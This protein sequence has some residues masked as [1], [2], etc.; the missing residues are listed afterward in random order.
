MFHQIQIR[1][2]D[3]HAQRLL[4]REDPNK[5]PDIYLMDV[6]TFGASCSPCSAQYVKNLNAEQHSTEYP[7]AA[8]AIIRK[9]YVDDYLD[10]ADNVEEAV[11]LAREVKHV[12]SQGGFYLRNWLSNSEEVLSRVGESDSATEKCLQL[13]RNIST[14]RV[15]GMFWRPEEDVFTFSTTLATEAKHPTKRQALRVVM[16]PFDPAGLLCLF[17]IHGKILIQDLWRAKTD[18]D[19]L[20]PDKSLE[21][22]LRWTDSFHQLDQIRIPRCY[23]A[24]HSTKDIVSL[25]LHVYVDASEEAYACVGYLRAV[26]PEEI[27]VALVGAKSKVAPLKAHSIPRLELMAAVIGVR[28]AKS[29]CN[30]H[31]LRIDKVFFWSDSKTVLAWINSDH[32]NYRQFVAC[33]V[34]EILSKSKAEEW[35]WIPSKKNVAD[36]ATKWGRGP[37][38]SSNSRWFRGEDDLYLPEESW[39]TSVYPAGERTNEELRSSMM[40]HEVKLPQLV[41]W[42]R[43]SNWTRLYRTVAY[44]HRYVRNLLRKTK[45]EERLVG[46]FTREEMG[47]AETT[48]FRWIQNERYPDEV[49]TLIS[50]K[51]KQ[52]NQQLRLEK[53]STIRKLSPF[54]DEADVIR[55]DSRIAAAKFVSYDTRFPVILPKGH[56]ATWLLVKW[57]HEKYLHANGETVVNEIRQRFHI[58]QLRSF[59]R[60]VSKECMLCK[61]KKSVPAI[62]RM[63]PLPA[64]RLQ[65]HVRPFSYIGIDYFGPIAVRVNRCTAKRWIA[66]FTCL[67]TRA[68]HL[69]VVHA[70]STESCKMAIRRFIG[71]RGAPVEIRSDRGTNFVG[72]SNE[73]KQEMATIE[74]QLAETFTNTH[75]DWVFNPPGAPHMGGAWER[76]VRSVKTALAAIDCPRTPSEE[77]LATVLVEAE[78]V[79]NSRPLTYIPLETDQQ[80]ALTPNHF[81]L[82]SSSGVSQTPKTLANPKQ[83]GRNDWNLC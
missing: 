27:K 43:F 57:F 46:P 68:I 39:T 70:L 14:E 82:L 71:R 26:F 59:V 56:Q 75:T 51:G 40:H 79:V 30:G 45:K 19:E 48:I 73:L 63:A 4:W 83:A 31:T 72:A 3:R 34:G 32:R 17:L 18:W 61:V 42:D 62:P 9:H 23:F 78:S 52:S 80:E 1:R 41:K 21:K 7:V 20:I 44:V 5:T 8:D 28:L 55:S 60:K 67:T 13:D 47:K 77:T 38:L 24:Q 33:R 74:N 6:A 12:H 69:E 49:T 29:I 22:W 58:S 10:S 81:L 25:Q 53:T 11:K 37:C 54:M 65:A 36:E 66:L 2:E 64:A 76:L 35:H 15:L 16:S 50:V